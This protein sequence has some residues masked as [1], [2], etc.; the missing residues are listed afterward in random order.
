MNASSAASQPLPLMTVM[1]RNEDQPRKPCSSA[2]RVQRFRDRKRRGV[3]AVVEVEVVESDIGWLEAGGY[4][5][6]GRRDKGALVE[7]IEAVLEGQ[8]DA[9]RA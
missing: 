2:E 1:H 4:L 7:A 3:I 9:A 8:A 6:A 5:L